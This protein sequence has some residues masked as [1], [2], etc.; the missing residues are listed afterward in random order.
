MCEHELDRSLH[1]IRSLWWSRSTRDFNKGHQ[2]SVRKVGVELPPTSRGRRLAASRSQAGRL[3]SPTEHT[4]D[5]RSATF[6]AA[7]RAYFCARSLSPH[8]CAG[9]VT[10]RDGSSGAFESPAPLP[11]GTW[12]MASFPNGAAIHSPSPYPASSSLSPSL[13]CSHPRLTAPILTEADAIESHQSQRRSREALELRDA[14]G[15]Y[16][17]LGLELR[18]LLCDSWA[19]SGAVTGRFVSQVGSSSAPWPVCAWSWYAV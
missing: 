14:A 8:A 10:T 7:P 19:A 15:G 1:V 5:G 12:S 6:S 13:P 9:P 16:A 3:G 18:A 4:L 2:K 11:A 17:Y